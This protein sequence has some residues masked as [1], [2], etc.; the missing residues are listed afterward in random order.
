MI[1]LDPADR[2]LTLGD[3]LFET[4]LA[5]NRVALW[6]HMHLARLEVA[7]GELGLAYDHDR[8]AGALDAL[9]AEI[10][11]D[12]HV[13]RITLTRGAAARGLAGQAKSPTLIAVSDPFDKTLMFQPARLATVSVR[14]SPSSPAARLKTLSYLDNVMAAREAAGKRA[15]DALMLNTNGHVACA[16][17]ANVFL[18][19]N[20]ALVTPARDQAILTGVTRQALIAAAHHIGV[21]T[22]ERAVAPAELLAADAVFLTNSLRLIRPVTALDGHALAAADLTPLADAL[23][24]A[25]KLQCGRDPRLI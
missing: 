19:K 3:G 15:D 11:P 4:L 8:V 1:A 23:C 14:R 18:M 6:R 25:A 21:A 22:E 20:G 17:I 5:V 9:L 2:G 24:A 7:A 12:P 13:L 16:A 10:S